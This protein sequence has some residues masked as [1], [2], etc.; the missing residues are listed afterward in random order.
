MSRT[1]LRWGVRTLPR[2]LRVLGGDRGLAALWRWRATGVLPGGEA[3]RG[4]AERRVAC[5]VC[6]WWW[7]EALGGGRCA[8]GGG[9]GVWGVCWSRVSPSPSRAPLPW[10]LSP[11]PPTPCRCH[12]PPPLVLS[13]HPGARHPSL[14]WRPG[15]PGATWARRREEEVVPSH[16]RLGAVAVLPPFP[17][18]LPLLPHSS[19]PQLR[20]VP[21]GPRGLCVLVVGD[22]GC[23]GWTRGRVP[24]L[25][26]GRGGPGWPVGCVWVVRVRLLPSSSV[27]G[28][29]L[30]SPVPCG[31]GAGVGRGG[32]WRWP[33]CHLPCLI[34][35]PRR[36]P[37]ARL[38]PLPPP[39][40]FSS[41]LSSRYLARSGAEV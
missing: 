39:P 8:A 4:E 18:P 17:L 2:L 33:R 13:L 26:R 1:G 6:V 24:S 21:R 9:D 11:P 27:S 7:E 28:V 41:R 23:W 34:R 25:P 32:V 36:R 12:L 30:S 10:L 38:A 16:A 20:G 14:R 3:R 19:H 35:F 37:R 40:N 5:V 15:R 29:R 22:G 31:R